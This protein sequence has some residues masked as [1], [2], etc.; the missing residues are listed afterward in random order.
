MTALNERAQNILQLIIDSYIHT[1]EPVGSKTIAERMGLTLSSASIRNVMSELEQSGFLYAPHTS[2]G[3]LP[4]E[5]GLTVFVEGLL[6]INDL[7]RK[8]RDIIRAGLETE[9]TG[10]VSDRLDQASRMLSGLSSG[11][12]LVIAPKLDDVL[13]EV[14]F[15]KL[16]DNRVLVVLVH[17]NGTVENRVV[18]MEEDIPRSNLIQ[19]AN[20]LN[21]FLG[22]QKLSSIRASLKNRVKQ[23]KQ[24]LDDLTQKLVDA[25]IANFS[26]QETGRHMI[27]RGQARLLDSVTALKDLERLRRLFAALE[28]KETLIKMLHAAEG[29]DGVQIFIGSSNSLF[30]HTGCSLIISPCKDADKNV[31]GAIGVIGPTRLNYRR[32]IPV[33]NYTS[34]L[35]SEFI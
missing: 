25:G 21:S 9:G 3:R 4:T 1:G 26:P 22:G 20:Y 35:L 34:E 27:I 32:V 2:A 8:E 19:A 16:S 29:A 15:L 18:E 12:G 23:E 11:A 17:D 30:E 10:P 28:E 5:A 24:V 33:I 7:P 31:I 14:E 13:K 6:E